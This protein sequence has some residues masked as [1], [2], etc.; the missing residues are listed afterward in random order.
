V[1]QESRERVLALLLG[2][3][4]VVIWGVSFAATR[5]AV[6]EVPP[7]TLAFLRFALAVVVLWPLVK[8]RWRLHRLRPGDRWAGSFLGLT[9]V[10]LAFVGENIALKLT[11]ASHAALIV[12]TTPLATAVVDAVARQRL[13]C[14]ATAGGLLVALAGVV[15]IVGSAKG[16]EGSVSGDLLMLATV[17]SWVAY[18]F[19]TRRL[20]AQYPT[21]VV[22]Q[23][24]LVVGAV[25]LAPLA[26]VESIVVGWMRPTVVTLL[27]LA[28]LGVFCSALAYLWWNRAIGVLGV[29]TTNSLIYGIPLV[30]VA[31][32]VVVLGEP[33]TVTVVAGGALIIAGVTGAS[34]RPQ[35]RARV[36]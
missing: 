23:I 30:G 3:A 29:T 36:R 22:T 13:P 27:A 26:M 4:V 34:W 19:L 11:T 25:T 1:S 6:R 35:R 10:T 21:L 20:T 8:R 5:V 32:G 16:S 24:A 12:A 9:G 31:A 15:L 17:S 7:M 2:A 18:S 28:Y 14:L 33:L